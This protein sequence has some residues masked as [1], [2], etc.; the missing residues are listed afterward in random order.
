MFPDS[1]LELYGFFELIELNSEDHSSVTYACV[2][3]IT[4]L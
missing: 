3:H 1:K 4:H 2:K